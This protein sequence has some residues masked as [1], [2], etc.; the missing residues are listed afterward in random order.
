MK[1][2]WMDKICNEEVNETR[3]MLNLYGAGNIIGDVLQHDELFCNLIIIIC[4]FIRRTMSTRR[5][6]LSVGSKNDWKAYTRRN[7]RQEK[8]I[9][10]RRSF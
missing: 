4:E 9:N 10:V 1:I 8:V 2:N 3:T 6:N 7:E 5:L